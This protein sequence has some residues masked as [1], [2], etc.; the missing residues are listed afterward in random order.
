MLINYFRKASG[1]VHLWKWYDADNCILCHSN[2]H[3][4]KKIFHILSNK[5]YV[6]FLKQISVLPYK[7]LAKSS[8]LFNHVDY[9]PN[10]L[11][12][13]SIDDYM[14][15]IVLN[16]FCFSCSMNLKG[17]SIVTIRNSLLLILFYVCRSLLKDPGTPT[18]GENNIVCILLNII[19]HLAE[20]QISQF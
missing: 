14:W 2:R 16:T 1:K 19:E 15:A 9:E 6:Y 10:F 5:W 12:F 17:I 11:V 4:F 7:I 3:G 13:H 20:M 8:L 18:T